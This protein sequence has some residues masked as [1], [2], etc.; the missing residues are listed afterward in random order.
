MNF[1]WLLENVN[2]LYNL[3]SLEMREIITDEGL[4]ARFQKVLDTGY[5]A[6]REKNKRKTDGVHQKD[7]V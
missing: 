5:R 6:I 7:K 1:A 4:N 3:L 2:V